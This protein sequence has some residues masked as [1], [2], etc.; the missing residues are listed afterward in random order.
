M[1]G[2]F[3]Q[4]EESAAPTRAPLRRAIPAD[5]I[6]REDAARP[7]G[8]LSATAGAANVAQSLPPAVIQALAHPPPPEP[9][10]PAAALP[11]ER[12]SASDLAQMLQESST[13]V[14]EAELPS[15]PF[16]SDRASANEASEASSS[17]S[18]ADDIE[19][20]P[21]VPPEPKS[22]TAL[23]VGLALLGTAAVG[24]LAVALT[25]ARR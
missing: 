11:V 17:A 18:S 20:F 6:E 15:K 8:P 19:L 13:N 12:T 22:S 4:A 3:T 7:T 24:G 1:L 5:R 10:P 9:A 14:T 2:L 23:W 25:R 21:L 16:S